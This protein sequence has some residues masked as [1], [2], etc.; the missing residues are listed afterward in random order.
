MLKSLI[1]CAC[2]VLQPLMASAVTMDLVTV[3]DPGNAHDTLR[4]YDL[5]WPGS[6]GYNY[7]IGIYE[8]RNS[9]YVEFLN[10]MAAFEDTYGLY[11][12]LMDSE[13]RGGITRIGSG[14]V[15][16]PY[17]YSAK[18]NMNDK[19]V[20]YVNVYDAMRFANWLDNGQPTGSQIAGTT[21]TGSYTMTGAASA[22]PRTPDAGWVLPT[23]DEWYK[24]AFYD[25]GPS[26]PTD[27][28]WLYATRSDSQPTVATANA[29]GDI[30]NPG[31]NVA[32]YDYGADWNGMNG[33]VTTVGSAG[34]LSS[35]YYGTFDQDGNVYEWSETLFGQGQFMLG[36][37][38]RSD[39]YYLQS[40]GLDHG[41]PFIEDYDRGF[42]VGFVPEPSCVAAA[43]IAAMGLGV[44]V[45]RR[46]RS[47]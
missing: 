38:W 7:Q 23:R 11:S 36:G 29:T 37:A 17:V 40:E 45:A 28:Y 22:S 21:E 20:N 47:D 42:R 35:S 44:R 19:P 41:T 10:A 32:N 1:A 39:R 27:D 4:T 16:D 6:V 46:S 34:P 5:E 15:G 30:S 3:G 31:A 33:N 14:T 43:L 25:P 12:S 9:E 26:G 18:P 2:V 13:T 8:V 24:A